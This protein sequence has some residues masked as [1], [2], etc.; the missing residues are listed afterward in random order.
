M[1]LFY[2]CRKAGGSTVVDAAVKSGLTLPDQHSNGNPRDG[3]GELIAWNQM[4]DKAAL[5]ALQGFQDAG[6]SFMCFE[7]STPKWSVI[8]KL[9]GVRF[10]TV[11][12]EPQARAF[13]N[14]RMA[15]LNNPKKMYESVF[16]FQSYMR[17]NALT[18]SSNYYTRFFTR[19]RPQ[20]ALTTEHLDFTL[21][22]LNDFDVVGVLE[23]NNLGDRFADLGFD[24]EAF[25]WKNASKSKKEFTKLEKKGQLDVSTYPTSPEFFQ[26]HNLD[27]TLYSYFLHNDISAGG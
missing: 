14:Y 22:R 19:A 4:E 12:R 25:G 10:A 1:I 17:G 15:V 5:E 16:G 20:D 23:R 7:F 8:D 6:V 27:A 2:H 26:A 13:S 24:P 3:S 21:N 18:T 9:K 11:L